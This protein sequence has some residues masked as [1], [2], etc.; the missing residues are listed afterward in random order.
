MS[1]RTTTGT[2]MLMLATAAACAAGGDHEQQ[3]E[4]IPR[5]RPVATEAEAVDLQR[6]FG[7]LPDLGVL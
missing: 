4:P 3:I 5:I 6:G 2:L 7:C 1:L